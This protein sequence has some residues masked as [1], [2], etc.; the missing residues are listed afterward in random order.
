L[1]TVQKAA[2]AQGPGGSPE[3][4]AKLLHL[5]ML[6]AAQLRAGRAGPPPAAPAAAGAAGALEALLRRQQL[7][8][9]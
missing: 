2:L 6:A 5:R 8:R 7:L 4:A 3:M 9:A 1:L